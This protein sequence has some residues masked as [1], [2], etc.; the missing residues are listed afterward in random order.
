VLRDMEHLVDILLLHVVPF[1]SHMMNLFN[2]FVYG[3]VLCVKNITTDCF[4][5]KNFQNLCL[6]LSHL[7]YSLKMFWGKFVNIAFLPVKVWKYNK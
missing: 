4:F 6:K 7:S 1:F 2:V 5:L 3:Y